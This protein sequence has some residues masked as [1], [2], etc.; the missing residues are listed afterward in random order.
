[1][2]VA[3][4][5]CANGKTIALYVDGTK[6]IGQPVESNDAATLTFRII[7]KTDE[8]KTVELKADDEVIYSK[9]VAISPIGSKDTS[10]NKN[11][12]I[13]AK[14]WIA[15][16]FDIENGITVRRIGAYMKRLYSNTLKD[17]V[18]IAELH[19]DDG[20][21]PA[22]AYLEK[23]TVP[24]TTPTLT[25][26]WIWFKFSNGAEL[27]PGKYWVVFKVD[28]GPGA[29]VSDVANIHYTAKDTQTAG[30]DYTRQMTLEWS[31]AESK[32]RETAWQPLPYDRTYAVIV[33][34]VSS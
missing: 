17:S 5:Q 7:P 4:V 1:M 29:I 33:S 21:K 11:D 14:E 22:S 18:V 32:Y 3:N 12:A 31:D 20:G 2:L 19:R 16:S 34:A 26:N 28:Q 25:E 10:G 30:N 23:T 15:S 8:T 13:S 24:I 6:L 27:Q 9:Q